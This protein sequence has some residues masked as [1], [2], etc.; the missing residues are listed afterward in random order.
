[1]EESWTAKTS[2][3]PMAERL[4]PAT[5]IVFWYWPTAVMLPEPSTARSVAVSPAV[6]PRPT[7]Q[8]V[9]PAEPTLA[10]KASPS[11]AL[12][13]LGPAEAGGAVELA[14]QVDVARAIQDHGGGLVEAGAAV[15][16]DPGGVA[17]AIELGQV[18]I[19]A[20]GAGQAGGAELGRAVELAG[21]VG[22]AGTVECQ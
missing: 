7:A 4:E 8:A 14:G 10:T 19:V 15:G 13:R 12:V 22:I 5:V 1:L 21:E 11:P 6:P 2:V 20:A 16:L 9:A 3:P 18:G 17:G